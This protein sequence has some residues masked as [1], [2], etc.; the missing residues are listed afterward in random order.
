MPLLEDVRAALTGRYSLERELGHGGMAVVFLGQDLKHRRPVAIK[1]LR[2]EV[3]GA[4]GPDRFLREIDIAANLAHPHIL[5]L[6]DSGAAGSL[7]YYV[8]PFIAGES[9]RERLRREP[10]LP[11][12]DALAITRQVAAALSFAHAHGVVHRDIKPENILLQGS[13][14]LVA[15]FGIARALTAAGGD[16][17]TASGVAVGTPAYMSPEQAL[18]DPT[19]DGRSDV[20]S[21][22]CVLYEMLSGQPPYT[23]ATAQAV[24]ARRLTEPMPSLRSVRA[25]VSPA[26]ESAVAR[27]LARA[28][29]DR[30]SSA[31]GFAAALVAAATPAADQPA[32]LP[33][34][35]TWVAAIAVVALVAWGVNRWLGSGT[36]TLDPNLLVVAPFR[37]TGGEPALSSLRNGM[38][39]LLSPLFTGQG[40]PRAVSPSAVL[41]HAGGPDASENAERELA[42]RLGAGL[43]LR[44]SVVMLPDRQVVLGASV[45]GAEDGVVRFTVTRRGPPDSLAAL[46]DDLAGELLVRAAGESGRRLATGLAAPLPVIQ[47]YLAGQVAYREGRW[48]TA[49]SHFNRALDL[50]STFAQAALGRANSGLWTDGGDRGIRLALAVRD[51][52]GPADEAILV[53]LAGPKY[54]APST[55]R[56]R[57]AAR[58]RAVELGADRPEAWFLL[59]DFLFHEGARVG[60]ERWAQRAGASFERA[61]ALDST[62]AEALVHLIALAQ[63]GGDAAALPRYAA[64]YL[65]IPRSDS[66]F[67][68]WL[69]A[70]RAGDSAGLA[71]IRARFA[72]M[73]IESLDPIFNTALTEGVAVADAERALAVLD[74]QARS[75]AER[76][77]VM[78]TQY[79]LA[80]NEGHPAKAAGI[81][82]Q[83]P[84]TARDPTA[85]LRWQVR[86]ALYWDGD[87]VAGSRAAAGLRR[88]AFGQPP[89]ELRL[90]ALQRLGRCHYEQ[91]EMKHGRFASVASTIA[92]LSDGD[93]ASRM[94]YGNTCAALLAAMRAVVQ[95]EPDAHALT[96]RLDS[97]VRDDPP[98]ALVEVNLLLAQLWEALGDSVLALAASRRWARAGFPL[99]V[100]S[101]VRMEGRLA[102]RSGDRAGA[103][104]AYRHYLALRSDPEPVLRPEVDQMKAELA[105]W[106]AEPD[107]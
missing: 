55:A 53:A 66:D 61:L 34:R 77:R 89:T 42:R 60:V 67:V 101:Y 99:M 43:A 84:N 80:L 92:L 87:T 24:T 83:Y 106:L 79:L 102:A 76:L 26:L 36:A 5:P 14:V 37:V 65:A 58:E 73:T 88:H 22:G 107:R 62:L 13:D 63:P 25:A 12:D 45:L 91:W 81:A 17:L 49:D 75:D 93:S 31:T 19:L 69:V 23:G 51:R 27:A 18:A 104:R 50:D 4:L 35:R 16:T 56:E 8:T 68:H 38:V 59:G 21:L 41:H 86:D 11:V 98:T 9:L 72:G 7:L 70:L 39:E 10:Q 48:A 82:S 33:R 32:A 47:S 15:D 85:S 100:T 94:V 95:R 52:L 28:P 2:P 3:A 71:R 44:G 103:I 64:Q 54:P 20:Y 6:F 90:H 57:L 74:Q 97:L 40:V 1:V 105:R 29:A 30:F 96:G 46:I 78:R